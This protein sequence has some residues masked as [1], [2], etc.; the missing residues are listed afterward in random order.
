MES[1][2]DLIYS[3]DAVQQLRVFLQNKV[4][5]DGRTLEER[6]QIYV[7]QSY[8]DSPSTGIF[9]SSHVKIGGTVVICALN[10]MVG[11]PSVHTPSA[12]DVGRL[13]NVTISFVND[14]L[15]FPRRISL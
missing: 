1:P 14:V 8:L 4:R 9:G 2:D 13:K 10:V 7:K 6:R 5:L 15:T 11:V 12:G 3:I